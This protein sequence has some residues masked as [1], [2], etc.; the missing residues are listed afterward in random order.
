M[1]R[2]D[3]L[4]I[5]DPAEIFDADYLFLESTYGNRDH[6]GFEESKQELLEAIKYAIDNRE[7]VLIPAFAVERTQELLYILSEFKR[8]N[9]IP[10]IPVY[11]DSPLA[12]KAT[13]IFRKNKA[14]Y[15]KETMAMVERGIDPLNMP[16][17]HFTISTKESMEINESPGPAIVIAGNGMCTGGRIRHHLKHNLWKRGVSLVIVGYQAKGTTGREI[18]DGAKYVRIFGEKVAVAARVFTIG[19]F[20]AHAGQKEILDWITHFESRPTIYITH[21]EQEVSE[22]LKAKIE[23]TF[24]FQVFVP[25]LR[26]KL[27]LKPRA[28]APEIEAPKERLRDSRAAL[29]NILLDMEKEIHRLRKA[30][31]SKGPSEEFSE[32]VLD[33]FGYLL[34][35]LKEMGL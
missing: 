25:K 9:E 29:L 32:E 34:E 16:N 28:K 19:G 20:S 33:R 14:F 7:K 27:I 26:D 11:L 24:G 17:L 2:R 18:V 21:G 30:A 23:E 4:L 5:E 31:E 35:E 22:V 12:I 15:D 13:E 10:D 3:Q 8:K 1:G 6:K